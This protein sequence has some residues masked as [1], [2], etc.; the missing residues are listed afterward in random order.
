MKPVIWILAAA[1]VLGA[2]YIWYSGQNAPTP[3][4]TAPAQ[5]GTQETQPAA[6]A[7]TTGGTAT[8]T[9]AED[10]GA[11]GGDGGLAGLL[12]V[13]GFDLDKVVGALDASDLGEAQKTAL[14][15]GL[16]QARDNPAMLRGMLDQVRAALGL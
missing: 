11:A 2:G 16:E 12:T 10:G 9:A 13:E 5:N 14:K 6:A 7:E 1:A 8:A 4:A 15:A 3:E